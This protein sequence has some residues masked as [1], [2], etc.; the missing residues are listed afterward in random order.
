ML[1]QQKAAET[2]L[3]RGKI[4]FDR[5]RFTEALLGFCVLILLYLHD[6]KHGP[7]IR[8]AGMPLQKR[9]ERVICV[10]EMTLLKKFASLLESFRRLRHGDK[11]G[12]KQSDR[13]TSEDENEDS[14]HR[15]KKCWRSQ[16]MVSL[17]RRQ[18]ERIAPAA[19]YP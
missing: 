16:A 11:C 4:R 6:P 12:H 9:F 14:L 5:K 10:C 17:F 18:F 3:R 1:V 19:R 15:E 2:S 8:V 13:R 7:C